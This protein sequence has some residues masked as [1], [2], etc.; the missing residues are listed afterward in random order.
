[1]GL[2]KSKMMAVIS[3]G[4]SLLRSMIRIVDHGGI[5]SSFS[6]CLN[7]MLNCC[8]RILQL[9]Y[10]AMRSQYKKTALTKRPKERR[11]AFVRTL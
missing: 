6:E 10:F 3:V 7:V 1:M 8:I 2:I 9:R 4:C 5:K 11:A